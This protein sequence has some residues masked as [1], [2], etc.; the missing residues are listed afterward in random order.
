MESKQI[1][2]STLIS[3]KKHTYFK[4][5]LLIRDKLLSNKRSQPPTYLPHRSPN[6][7]MAAVGATYYYIAPDHVSVGGPG[8]A[9]IDGC[10]LPKKG[11]FFC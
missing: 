11:G 1:L 5:L 10:I 7:R 4:N 3:V 9:C 2:K 8:R 6:E